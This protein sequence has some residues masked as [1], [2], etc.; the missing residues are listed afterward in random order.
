MSVNRSKANDPRFWR[1]WYSSGAVKQ[2]RYPEGSL[3]VEAIGTFFSGPAQ[4]HS[5]LTLGKVLVNSG[6]GWAV[7][8]PLC[9]IVVPTDKA[10]GLGDVLPRV[11]ENAVPV[12][13]F[14]PKEK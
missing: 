11:P 8:R 6:P 7:Y 4:G 1:K 2:K 12:D 9:A 13:V 14:F 10:W 5:T 3:T